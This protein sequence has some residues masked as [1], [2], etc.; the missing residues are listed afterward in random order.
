M[1]IHYLPK[2]PKKPLFAAN[3]QG[4]SSTQLQALEEYKIKKAKY[5]EELKWYELYKVKYEREQQIFNQK[6]KEYF[7]EIIFYQNRLYSHKKTQEKII[8][9]AIYNKLIKKIQHIL[10]CIL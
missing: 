6:F 2:E 4:F 5:D 9:N 10:I 8:L 3:I 1:Q 7:S